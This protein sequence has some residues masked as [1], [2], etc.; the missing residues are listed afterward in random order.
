MNDKSDYTAILGNTSGVYP[1]RIVGRGIYREKDVYEF[2]TACVTLD[3]EKTVEAVKSFCAELA[4]SGQKK[5]KV[6]PIMPKAV[7]ERHL[8]EVRVTFENI[9][10]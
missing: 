6:V 9:P 1:S 8:E 5:A 10:I 7:L 4:R 3:A 2:Q